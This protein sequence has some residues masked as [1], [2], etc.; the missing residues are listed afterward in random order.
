[1]D[2]RRHGSSDIRGGGGGG[3]GGGGIDVHPSLE[4]TRVHLDVHNAMA[5]ASSKLGSHLGPCSVIEVDYFHPPATAGGHHKVHPTI[6]AV[7]SV[8]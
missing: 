5:R 7:I 3:G 2:H 4:S 8:I 6:L 1:M